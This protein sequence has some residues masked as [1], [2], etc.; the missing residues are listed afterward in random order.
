MTR[1]EPP[2]VGTLAMLALL[3]STT[4]GSAARA[5][6][7]G[8]RPRPPPPP[9]PPSVIVQPYSLEWDQLIQPRVRKATT[10]T[11]VTGPTCAL[12]INTRSHVP[13]SLLGNALD[14]VI[15]ALAFGR[16]TGCHVVVNFEVPAR[17]HI[18]NP[19]YSDLVAVEGGSQ[20]P[21]RHPFSELFRMDY[22]IPDPCSSA[23]FAR[24]CPG[25]VEMGSSLLVT[26]PRPPNGTL[27][28]ISAV[29]SFAPG[30][31]GMADASWYRE[32]FAAAAAIKLKLK[33]KPSPPS[34]LLP[35]GTD[36]SR[37][38]NESHT[39]HPGALLG[40]HLRLAYLDPA[41]PPN[42]SR[43]ACT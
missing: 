24:Y 37:V 8:Y 31:P 18:T 27:M 39:L 42:R 29:T 1:R 9:A 19:A 23:H 30:V 26:V 17:V 21:L 28:D 35:A 2:V 11:H 5:R 40:I 41:A 38:C 22:R 10:P 7:S 13:P 43:I 36:P 25:A 16:V 15:A 6:T 33:L 4:V 32:Y 14:P 3:V 34:P 12:R 20:L